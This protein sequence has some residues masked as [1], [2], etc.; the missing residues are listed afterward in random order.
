M[1]AHE[2]A[3]LLLEQPNVP[4]VIDD[5]SCGRSIVNEIMYIHFH[6]DDELC[7]LSCPETKNTILLYHNAKRPI[8]S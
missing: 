2:L 7:P 3:K 4:V 8:I 6:P 5:Y 1:T